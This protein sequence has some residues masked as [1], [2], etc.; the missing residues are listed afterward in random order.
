MNEGY[1]QIDLEE[2]SSRHV[3]TFYGGNGKKRY[4]RLN[5]GTISSQDIFGNIMTKTTGDIP[6]VLH[7]RDDILVHGKTQ[8]EHNAAVL[9]LLRRFRE[10]NLTLRKS[11]C[12]F[13]W[14]EI[15]FFG[16]IF[17]VDGTL[18]RLTLFIS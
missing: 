12:K 15:N 8:Q 14:S 1:H 18:K 3:T 10:C 17:S 6:G 16:F 4:T 5:H 9:A 2:E 13:N 11:K 7:I